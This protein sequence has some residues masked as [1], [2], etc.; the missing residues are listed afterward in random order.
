[1]VKRENEAYLSVRRLFGS[2]LLLI[3]ALSLSACAN[4]PVWLGGM[5]DDVPPRR[6]TPEYETWMAQRAQEAARPKTGDQQVR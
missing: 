6:G 2:A 1:M 5:P 3:L 4:A